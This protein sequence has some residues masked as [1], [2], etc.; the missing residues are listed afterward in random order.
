MAPN[1]NTNKT[2]RTM[3]P[4]HMKITK[5]TLANVSSIVA[6]HL[7]KQQNANLPSLLRMVIS[8]RKYNTDVAKFLKNLQIQKEKHFLDKV[9]SELKKFMIEEQI[10][11]EYV[12]LT[13]YPSYLDINAF[14]GMLHIFVYKD[15]LIKIKFSETYKNI[16]EKIN[17][18]INTTP[19]ENNIFTDSLAILNFIIRTYRYDYSKIRYHYPYMS[20]IRNTYGRYSYYHV[21][22]PEFLRNHII[23]RSFRPNG[24]IIMNSP[25]RVNF[26]TRFFWTN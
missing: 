19:M 18:G 13:Q 5:P 3:K 14:H 6:Q 16:V 1:S 7:G 9:V 2:R 10:P 17:Q 12:T 24:T 21:T 23:N 11:D 25:L 22:T 4:N 8:E 20:G 26:R 15:Y